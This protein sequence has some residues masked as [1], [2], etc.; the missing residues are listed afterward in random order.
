[1]LVNFFRR[2]EPKGI[3][4]DLRCGQ[5]RDS[6]ALARMGYTVIGVDISEVGISHMMNVADKER[7]NIIGIVDDIYGY[8]IDETI[9]VVILDSMLNFNKRDKKK[10]PIF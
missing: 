7:L 5:G 10:K 2:Y 9:D 3:V 4:L 6:I 1:M 8:S